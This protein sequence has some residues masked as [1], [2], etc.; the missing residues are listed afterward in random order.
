MY[1]EK[2]KTWYVKYS[3]SVM[4]K[5]IAKVWVLWTDRDITPWREN[6]SAILFGMEAYEGKEKTCKW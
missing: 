2:F 1:F 5:T 3:G 6:P 4:V